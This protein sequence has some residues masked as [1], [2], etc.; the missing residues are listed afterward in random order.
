MNST[1]EFRN[2]FL[3]TI[4]QIIRE[5]VRNM[6]VPVNKPAASKSD[7]SGRRSG[8][9]ADMARTL[10]GGKKRSKSSQQRHSAGNMDQEEETY[11]NY[12]PR[13]KTVSDG[14]DD[15][16]ATS[17]RSDRSSD[18]RHQVGSPVWKP[19][20]DRS[21]TLPHP[22]KGHHHQQQQQQY[23][24]PFYKKDHCSSSGLAK[25]PLEC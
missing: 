2:A 19:R 1:S 10:S 8:G 11:D 9:T 20:G 14:I 18:P 25:P 17:D 15:M 3:R 23:G 22:P 5:S 21:A 7:K 24:G 4:R 16:D 6:T 12:T 13:S